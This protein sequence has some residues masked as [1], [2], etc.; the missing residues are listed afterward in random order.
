V[1][2]FDALHVKVYKSFADAGIEIPNSKHEV[3]IKQMPA[4]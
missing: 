1:A 3:Y 2:V 4:S